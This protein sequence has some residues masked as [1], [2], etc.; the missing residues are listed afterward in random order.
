MDSISLY[1]FSS[2]GWLAL[3][4]IPLALWPTF[5]ISLLTPDFRHASAVDQHLARSLG[6]SQLTIGVLLVVLTGSLPLTSLVET[7]SGNITPFSN[8]AIL[9]STLYHGAYAFST[10]V[11]Y[12]STGQMGYLVGAVGY[13]I[14]GSF[15]LWCLMFG[16]DKGHISKRTGADKRTSG[17]PF[18][19]AEA[20][21]RRPKEL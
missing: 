1:S 5:V 19:N 10:Y 3:Q 14:F 12:N 6:F 7:P 18:K 13:S 9:V 20:D 2:F 8:A 15:G 11:Q 16:G 4:S 17:F 21:K